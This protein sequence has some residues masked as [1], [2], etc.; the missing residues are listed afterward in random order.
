MNDLPLIEVPVGGK[1]GAGDKSTS[2]FCKALG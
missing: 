2:Y 1:A